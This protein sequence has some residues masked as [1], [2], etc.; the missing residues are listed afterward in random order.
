MSLLRDIQD[1]AISTDTPVSV[2]LRQC[3]VLAA[4]LQHEPLRDWAQLEL[5]GY[6]PD[7]PLPPYRPKITAHVLGNF[8]GPFGSG[9]RNMNLPESVI[10]EDLR[11]GLFRVEIREGVA[12]IE[13]LVNSGERQF[14]MPW[15]ADVVATYQEDFVETMNLVG[16][17]KVVPATLFLGVLSGIRDRIVQFALE[18]E[19]LDPA[20]GEADPG[21]APIEQAQ[22]TQ[23]FNQT[24][25]GDNTAFAAAGNTV[26]QTQSTTI[27]TQAVRETADVF[28]IS[29]QERNLL[30]SAIQKDGG[31]AGDE[32]REWVDRLESGA[33]AVG[34]GVATQ[35]AVA[36]LLGVL[37]LS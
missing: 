16:A 11:D 33:I 27:D 23:I 18:I 26:N 15:P 28:G 8:S 36:A 3:L 34:T 19:E 32:T 7:A 13:G 6:P 22:V 4:R 29:E 25:Y 17:R 12:H 10:P 20:A 24:F 30:L 31:I 37:G 9:A 14:E 35:T 2:L 1:G 21:T 5:N